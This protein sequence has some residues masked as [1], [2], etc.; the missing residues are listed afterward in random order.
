MPFA[1]KGS[2]AYEDDVTV[3][4]E[5][6]AIWA[7][8]PNQILRRRC[9]D[10]IDSHKDIYYRRFDTNGLPDNFDLLEL[11]KNNWFSSP[12]ISH[13]DF[14]IDFNL[15]STY[16]DAIAERNEWQYCNFS[17]LN[18]AGVGFPRDCAPTSYTP[19]QFNTFYP[20]SSLGKSD[21]GFYVEASVTARTTLNPSV[22][23][24]MVS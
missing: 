13:N 4:S 24:S 21:I 18:Y 8:S 14:K 17:N 16:E 2:L 11:V 9:L 12:T 10:C 20:N 5:F 6:N 22:D 19:H 23:P 1:N 3:L 15:Y 7:Q